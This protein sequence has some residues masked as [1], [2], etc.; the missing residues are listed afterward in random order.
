MIMLPLGIFAMASVATVVT[1]GYEL[2]TRSDFI[3]GSFLGSVL[4]AGSFLGAFI[5]IGNQ[6]GSRH[7]AS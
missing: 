7:Q 2:F 3:D 6:S 5:S 4:M 1:I